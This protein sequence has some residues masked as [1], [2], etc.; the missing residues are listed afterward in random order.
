MENL[1][2]LK[3][4]SIHDCPFN[5]DLD[6]LVY[7][8][9]EGSKIFKL[10]H[11]MQCPDLEGVIEQVALTSNKTSEEIKQMI[12][13]KKITLTGKAIKETFKVL[14]FDGEWC[15]NTSFF[16]KNKEGLQLGLL[17]ILT[18]KHTPSV[19]I[20][21]DVF[22]KLLQEKKD[23]EDARD[24]EL[25]NLQGG[26]K[27]DVEVEKKEGG[28]VENNDDSKRQRLNDDNTSSKKKSVDSKRSKKVKIEGKK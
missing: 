6:T 24:K 13:N 12:A 14:G 9:M 3:M 19:A 10:P 11:C 22:E 28:D 17:D 23:A 25:A 5:I 16:E 2:F 26:A 15:Y 18:G 8:Q 20:R 27:I 7:Q 1:I 4:E 21:G